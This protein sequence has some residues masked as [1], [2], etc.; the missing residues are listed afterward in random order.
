MNELENKKRCLQCKYCQI[1]T[2]FLLANANISKINKCILE[3]EEIKSIQENSLDH[4]IFYNNPMEYLSYLGYKDKE[5]YPKP[6]QTVI[7]LTGGF[8]SY[9]YG[10]IL[11][12]H[13]EDDI[14][15]F[16]SDNFGEYCVQK[17]KWWRKLFKI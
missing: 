1:N 3:C 6:G 7:T 8:G 4:F 10:K 15:I 2:C 13:S 11:T 16:L 5:N 12:V 17:S 14:Q 9:N